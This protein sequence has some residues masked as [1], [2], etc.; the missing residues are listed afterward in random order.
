MHVTL[1]KWNTF[2]EIKKIEILYQYLKQY[3]FY[4][5]N[6]NEFFFVKHLKNK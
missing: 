2:A 1:Y 4:F 6:Y 3:F 5:L